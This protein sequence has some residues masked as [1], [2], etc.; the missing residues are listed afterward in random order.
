MLFLNNER[1]PVFFPEGSHSGNRM[2][3][4]SISWT[5]APNNSI[6]GSSHWV[7]CVRRDV[8]SYSELSASRWAHPSLTGGRWETYSIVIS[9]DRDQTGTQFSLC[10]QTHTFPIAGCLPWADTGLRDN[11]AGVCVCCTHRHS[12]IYWRERRGGLPRSCQRVCT[13]SA[14]FRK[15]Q[16]LMQGQPRSSWHLRWPRCQLKAI[17]CCGPAVCLGPWFHE[18]AAASG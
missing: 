6:S 8:T 3:C 1:I 11:L 4:I 2:W 12:H 7:R 10:L 15:E 16:S 9:G 18:A 5:A 13:T 17:C 14:L